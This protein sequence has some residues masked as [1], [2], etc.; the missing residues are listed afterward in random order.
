MQAAK[1]T[2]VRLSVTL[3]DCVLFLFFPSRHAGKSRGIACRR[4]IVDTT[5]LRIVGGFQI[6]WPWN[7]RRRLTRRQLNTGRLTPDPPPPQADPWGWQRRSRFIGAMAGSVGPPFEADT[8]AV[9]PPSALTRESL[10]VP[11]P[12]QQLTSEGEVQDGGVG[13]VQPQEFP[14]QP[15]PFTHP[16]VQGADAAVGMKQLYDHVTEQLTGVDSGESV[17]PFPPPGL[18]PQNSAHTPR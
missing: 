12:L 2:A 15:K 7:P 11:L 1:S 8:T 14:V 13:Y 10:T 18:P 6:S 3:N 4:Q 16:G 17:A 5:L 9:T